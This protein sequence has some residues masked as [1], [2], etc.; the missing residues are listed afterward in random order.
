MSTE[1]ELTPVKRQTTMDLVLEQLGRLES[2]SER[3]EKLMAHMADEVVLMLGSI[4]T[5]VEDSKKT[6]DRVTALELGGRY[7]PLALSSLTLL[8]STVAII[9]VLTW[10]H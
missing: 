9:L 8:W 3:A 5:L 6:R 10:K 1:L 7:I 2:A 4:Q